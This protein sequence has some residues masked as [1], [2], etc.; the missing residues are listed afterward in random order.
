MGI[1]LLSGRL[2]D[3]RDTPDAP[4]RVVVSQHVAD[5][6]WPGANVLGKTIS[7][8]WN[9]T[10]VAEIVGV[11]GD[12]RHNGPA[13]PPRSMLYW[14]YRQFQDF[15]DVTLVVR[16]ATD[17]MTLAP[18]LRNQMKAMDRNVPLYNV[19]TMDSYFGDS[20]AQARFSMIALGLFAMLAVTLACVGIFGVMS[21]SVNQRVRE[22]GIRMALGASGGTVTFRIVRQGAILVGIA[23]V[24][25]VAGGLALSR[26]LSG[27]VFDISPTDPITFVFVSAGL[28]VVALTACYIPAHRASRVD[29]VIALKTE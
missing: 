20:L 2:F 29:P 17:P 19:R 11:V 13:Q 23:I 28:A 6:F 8:P 25:G 27:M 14:N 21:Y 24:L 5:E 12:I 9:D 10:L 16:A 1:P 22:I 26:F 4:M 18:A 3:D 15:S 7:M